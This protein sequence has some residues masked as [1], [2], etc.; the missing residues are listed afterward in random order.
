[1]DPGDFEPLHIPAVDL[2]ERR[3]AHSA[4]IAAVVLPFSRRIFCYRP[5][6]R[7]KGVARA[8]ERCATL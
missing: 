4:G 3:V 1:M 2:I 5:K 8:G 6:T 7:S